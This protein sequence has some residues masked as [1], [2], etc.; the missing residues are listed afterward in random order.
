MV[1]VTGGSFGRSRK[2][3]WIEMFCVTGRQQVTM[4][5]PVRERGLKYC[6]VHCAQYLAKVAPVRERGLK[7]ELLS[8]RYKLPRV[9]PVRERGLKCFDTDEFAET[10][11]RSL[12]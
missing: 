9:A 3:A 4:V 11:Y 6:Y 2:G 5:A 10:I 8:V 7:Y 1:V 12:P